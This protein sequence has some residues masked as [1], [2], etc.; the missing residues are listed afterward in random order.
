VEPSEYERLF[1]FE[2]RHWRS[3]GIRRLVLR[4]LAPML[5]EAESEPR[6]LEAGCGC[7]YLALALGERMHVTGVDASAR[8]LAY[9]RRRGLRRLVR[10]D[11]QALPFA[12]GGFDAVVSVDLLYHREVAD[13]AAALAELGRVCRPGGRVVL[14]V[15]AYEWMR[16]PHDAVVHTARRYTR[17][18]VVAL[19]E[20]AGLV[21]EHVGY[22]NT[23]VLPL[24]AARRLWRGR[25]AEPAS[26]LGLPREPVNALAAAWLALEARAATRVRLPFGL[27]VFAALRRTGSA[28]SAD[29]EE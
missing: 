4:A 7:G 12:D 19:A 20:R 13:D 8:A 27:S 16:S 14:L 11:V 29:A 15:A 9:C 17:G 6:V 26:D 23:A 22:F 18:A 2:E 10:A 24:A 28:R 1:A 5:A 25:D 21:P 3:R